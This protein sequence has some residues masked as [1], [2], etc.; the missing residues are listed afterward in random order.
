[1]A[2]NP[3]FDQGPYNSAGYVATNQATWP[4][5]RPP[6]TLYQPGMWWTS[7]S[8][9]TVDG[10]PAKIGDYIFATYQPRTFGDFNYGDGTYGDNPHGDWPIASVGF[11][12]Y[13]ASVPPTVQPPFPYAGC[14]FGDQYPGWRIVVDAMYY[15]TPSRTYGELLYGDGVYGD[16]GA[17]AVRGWADI[18]RP[19]FQVN[20]T[21]GTTDGAPAVSV[22]ELSLQM[23]DD[24]GEWIDIAEPAYYNL[25]FVGDPIRVGFLD[26][27]LAYHPVAVGTIETILD[28]HDTL[29]RYVSVQAFGN[30][31][32]LSNDH[33][34]W[35]RPAEKTSV[36]FEAL[37]AAGGWRFG[38]GDLIFPGDIDLHADRTPLDIVT[39]TEI[40][41]TAMSAGWFFDTD[42]WG[43][44]RL[45][46]WPHQPT[47][48]PLEVVDCL[49]EPGTPPGALLSHQISYGADQSQILNVAV[50]SNSDD[51]Q[52]VVRAEEDLSI[53]RFGRKTKAMGFPL[54]DLAF[55]HDEDA[56]A[57]VVRYTNRW[58]YIVRHVTAFDTDTEVD[59]RW[60]PVLVDLDTGRAVTVTRTHIHPM[61]LD[62]VVVGFDHLITPGRFGS[63]VNV[64]TLTQTL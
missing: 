40:D 24:E 48:S 27:G 1:M 30:D 45:R 35:Q 43:G 63:T 42:R 52:L 53:S 16:I 4:Q 13:D 23:S 50:V 46:E 10:Y 32:D 14:P 31:M 26:P 7:T 8:A 54:G 57:L 20:V 44:P 64:A 56:A 11:Y 28:E 5:V 17:N 38:D 2:P 15:A 33:L 47:G 19:V 9:G 25:P 39:R 34:Y 36:R 3:V 62:A 18:T 59:P 41:R 55:A 58:A 37:M 21:V 22:T 49:G 12:V 61:V 29:P 60:L 51:P 6:A